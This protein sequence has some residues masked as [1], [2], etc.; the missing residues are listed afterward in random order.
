VFQSIGTLGGGNHFIEAGWTESGLLAVTIHSGS[1]N[2]GLK[3]A[4]YYQSIAKAN[5]DSY[6]FERKDLEFL[7]TNSI[8]GQAY[9]YATRVAQQYASL[10]RVVM[11]EKISS[12]LKSPIVD[13]V[14]TVHNYIGDDNI[15]RKG[16]V[17]AK[18]GKKIILP[19]NMAD[20]LAICVGKGNP[21]Y[22]YSAPH[23]AG[24]IMGRMEAKRSLDMGAFTE[25][26]RGVYTTTA[27]EDTLD[28]APMA[29]KP[30]ES[31]ISCIG[32]TLEIKEF[33]KPVYNFKA[34]C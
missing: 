18:A 24:R 14:E 5:C 17:S 10:N 9:L 21:E 3:I 29:Y 8:D 25:R 32:E 7:L 11:L 19:F 26:M 1:R 16:A 6:F 31:I 15:I 27:T 20:G 22:N 12:F 23:G 13:T 33:V 2:F 30:M 28:E 34:I 4:N